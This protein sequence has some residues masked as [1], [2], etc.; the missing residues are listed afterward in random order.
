MQ[1]PGHPSLCSATAAS[2]TYL[3]SPAPADQHQQ[4]TLGA[5]DEE[6]LSMNP[7]NRSLKTRRSCG[8]TKSQST[9]HE[10]TTSKKRHSTSANSRSCTVQ[11][12]KVI[13]I[14]QTVK[15]QSPVSSSTFQRRRQTELHPQL[16]PTE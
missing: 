9:P 1:A 16:E 7:N 15:H 10:H 8:S 11:L 14:I 4:H 5:L 12:S 3:S 6:E 13:L 2:S